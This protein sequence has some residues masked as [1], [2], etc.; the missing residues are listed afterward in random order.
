LVERTVP[1]PTEAFETWLLHRVA[2]AVEAGEV[3]VNLLTGL[4]AEITE[5]REQLP[6]ERQALAVQE[7]AE[8]FGLL[9]DRHTELLVTLEAQPHVTRELLL[10]RFVEAWLKEQREEYRAGEHGD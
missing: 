8:R 3:S 1:N 10:R 9:V 4:Q 6:E 2:R 7:L 5:A